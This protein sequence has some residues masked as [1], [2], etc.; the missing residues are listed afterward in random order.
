KIAYMPPEQLRGQPIDLRADVFALGI[1]LYE[2]VTGMKPFD[3]TS[4]V[5]MMQAILFEPLV[6]AKSRR[7][8]TPDAL[9]KIIER[10][11]EKNREARYPTCR[12]LHAD[13]ERYLL[14]TGEPVGQFQLA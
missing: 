7:P 6:P 5:S 12:E 3:A 4:E 2:L 11:M 13:L 1:V 10:A 14:S 8:D 9:H